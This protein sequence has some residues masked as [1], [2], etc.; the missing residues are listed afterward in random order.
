[1]KRFNEKVVLV[2]GAASGMGRACALRF[3]QEGARV[4]A[5]DVNRDGLE[6]TVRKMTNPGRYMTASVTDE[7]A[8]KEVFKSIAH[9]EG[10]LDAVAHMAGILRSSVTSST[11]VEEF[12]VPI[13]VNLLGTFLINREAIPLLIKTKGSIVNAA[14]TSSFFGHP[15]MAA[16]A[17]SK[18]GVAAM[19]S[20]LAWEYMKT[21]IR[22][23]AVAP[24]GIATNMI[25]ENPLEHLGTDVD[26]T[27]ME[28]LKRMDLPYGN[29]EDVAGVV[30][31]LASEDGAFING[32]IIRIDGGNHS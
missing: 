12:M 16:Y 30:A 5:M 27:L 3:A 15:Y 21:G 20:T 8:V 24:G 18:G 11:S 29:P 31:M 25:K 4:V 17:A 1:M 10:K 7:D 22:I 19:T 23:N 6:E 9:T 13:T 26:Y 2:T 28:H 14:S 32:E